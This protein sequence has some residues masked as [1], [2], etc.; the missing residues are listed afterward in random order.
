MRTR[1]TVCAVVLWCFAR[2]T[3]AH[4]LYEAQLTVSD[5]LRE[6]DQALYQAGALQVLQKV[7]MRQVS[8]PAEAIS[9]VEQWVERFTLTPTLEV[10][11]DTQGNAYLAQQL[12][13]VYEP[14]SIKRVLAQAKVPYLGIY[15]PCMRFAVVAAVQGELADQQ[16]VSAQAARLAIPLQ[17]VGVMDAWRAEQQAFIQRRLPRWQ[18][19]IAVQG[20]PDKKGGMHWQL[21]G[22]APLQASVSTQGSPDAQLEQLVQWAFQQYGVLLNKPALSVTEKVIM[23]SGVDTLADYT[24]IT[25]FFGELPT[26]GSVRIVSQ[27]GDQLQVQFKT[28]LSDEALVR[29]LALEPRLVNLVNADLGQISDQWRWYGRR[30]E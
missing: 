13:L 29:V 5:Q 8:L 28:R 1:Y 19:H 10:Q 16:W 21:L 27:I 12:T 25:R 18:C 15:R 2:F 11:H 30:S 9:T 6:P 22:L 3:G 7:A 23:I 24:A 14:S 26:L 17:W 4:P 20:V